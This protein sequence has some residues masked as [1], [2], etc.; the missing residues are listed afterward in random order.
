MKIYDRQLN[1]QEHMDNFIM[2][3]PNGLEIRNRYQRNDIIN[4]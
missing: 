2:D 4:D 1:I 3:A